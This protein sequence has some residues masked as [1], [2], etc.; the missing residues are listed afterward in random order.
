MKEVKKEAAQDE[1]QDLK[2]LWSGKAV[3]FD[4][5]GSWPTMWFDIRAKELK[6]LLL[7]ISPL[8]RE[9]LGRVQD[10]SL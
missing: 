6:D 7:R 1:R 2:T 10:C 8:N 9:Q 3:P 5:P 4:L